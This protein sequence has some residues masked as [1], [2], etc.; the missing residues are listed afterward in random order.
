MS[1]QSS[2]FSLSLVEKTF[3]P[4]QMKRPP[5]LQIY[6]TTPGKRANEAFN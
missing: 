4:A 6:Q 1:H 5:T 2:S 3:M